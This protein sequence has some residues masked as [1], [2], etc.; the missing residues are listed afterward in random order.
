MNTVFFCLVAFSFIYWWTTSRKKNSTEKIE[1]PLKFP[2]SIFY[3]L[4][5]NV[6]I[7]IFLF[8]EK[9]KIFKSTLNVNNGIIIK[10]TN[11]R[12]R[13]N[14]LYPLPQPPIKF[15]SF[16]KSNRG[17]KLWNWPASN[18]SSRCKYTLNKW[19]WGDRNVSPC[20]K[21][22]RNI[23]AEMSLVIFI[24]WN[25]KWIWKDFWLNAGPLSPLLHF[26]FMWN[27]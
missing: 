13:K 6:R 2:S 25:R 19:E 24:V 10:Q 5:H 16:W 4:D 15:L 7:F 1:I 9:R 20:N 8:N 27:Q 22:R 12:R 21:I 18:Q 23:F 3:F 17:N 14:K 26:T 11:K